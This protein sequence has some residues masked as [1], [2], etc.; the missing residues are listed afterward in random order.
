[1]L[2]KKR[3]AP[4][5]TDFK[6]L[7]HKVGRRAPAPA[8]ATDTSFKSKQVV[9]REQS[10]AA[11]KSSAGQVASRKQTVEQ[12]TSLTQHHHQRVRAEAFAGLQELAERRA[13]QV[14]QDFARH[15]PG[16]CKA[17]ADAEP[18]VRAGF[19]ATLARLC[20]TGQAWLPM[21]LDS[22]LKHA[23]AALTSAEGV[24]RRLDATLVVEVLAEAFP[25][26][27]QAAAP[28]LVPLYADLCRSVLGTSTS[29][30]AKG[31]GAPGAP[32]VLVQRTLGI[33]KTLKEEE[34]AAKQKTAKKKKTKASR[35]GGAGA[36]SLRAEHAGNAV[37]G[38]RAGRRRAR[39]DVPPVAAGGGGPGGPAGV[40]PGAGP[41]PPRGQRVAGGGG[42]A[43][44]R[45]GRGVPALR[46][47]RGERRRAGA[48]HGARRARGLQRRPRA[49]QGLPRGV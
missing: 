17:M 32:T 5:N 31:S 4:A 16:L 15:L 35:G 49:G 41:Q 22:L 46:A 28:G 20:V 11:D 34:A 12:L 43:G 7:K 2:Q 36:E 33:L 8:N 39:A 42:R 30:L 18:E 10:V 27:L 23:T 26:A 9:I 21:H 45:G 13:P 25:S 1:M 19:R 29:S 47:Q 40:P 6:P 14:Q 44:A 38:L 37:G 24:G 3:K 48:V